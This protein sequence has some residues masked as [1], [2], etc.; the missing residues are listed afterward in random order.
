MS[1]IKES[2]QVSKQQILH[3]LP[4]EIKEGI[5]GESVLP[6]SEPAPSIEQQKAMVKQALPKEFHADFEK[7]VANELLGE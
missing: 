7:N 4:D 2:L 6:V 1:K 3:S 5:D